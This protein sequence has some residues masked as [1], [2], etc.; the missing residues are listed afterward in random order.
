MLNIIYRVVQNGGSGV[1]RSINIVSIIHILTA[2]AEQHDDHEKQFKDGSEPNVG[3]GSY[4]RGG[5]DDIVSKF[6]GRVDV[7]PG[8][9]K[10]SVFISFRH[11]RNDDNIRESGR[12]SALD[13]G[14]DE[15]KRKNVK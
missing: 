12:P 5:F 4:P 11:P 13:S 10:C 7:R 6:S 8:G 15:C 3:S 14:S 9:C 2:E 1:Y